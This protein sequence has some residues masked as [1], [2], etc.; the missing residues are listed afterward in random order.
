[1]GSLQTYA[2]PPSAPMCES[3]LVLIKLYP[4]PLTHCQSLVAAAGLALV[5]APSTGVSMTCVIGPVSVYS[6]PSGGTLSGSSCITTVMQ[7]AGIG[8]YSCSSG[9]LS[10][11]SCVSGSSIAASVSYSCPA[12]QSL[13]GTTCSLS[14]GSTTA[15]TPSYSCPSGYTLS[16]A[17]CTIQGTA[18]VPATAG[19]SCPGGGTLSGT[20]CVGVV[21]RTR[22]EAYGNTAA[23]TVPTELG[24]TGHVNDANTGL[25]YMQQRYY[26]PVAGRFLSM[27]PVTTDTDTGAAFDRYMYANNNPYRYTDPDGRDPAGTIG[28][29]WQVVYQSDSSASS[30]SAAAPNSGGEGKSASPRGIVVASNSYQDPMLNMADRVAGVPSSKP[31]SVATEALTPASNVGL[32]QAMFPATTAYASRNPIGG[33]PADQ[34]SYANWSNSVDRPMV[35]LGARI[36]IGGMSFPG[37]FPAQAIGVNYLT[38]Q[39]IYHFVQFP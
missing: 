2:G 5:A 34:I 22:Y 24:F 9:T 29:H 31:D 14:S 7:A 32:I 27:D 38:N 17:S 23:G 8:S 1:V 28:E 18:T 6:C 12:G 3:V 13:S 35:V 15:G 16:G 11:S 39:I 30:G 20:S 19:Y 37:S 25:V 26:D 36:T 33:S 4:A 10:G 21:S